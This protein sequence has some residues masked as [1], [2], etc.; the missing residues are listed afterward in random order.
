VIFEATT[1]CARFAA[2]AGSAALHVGFAVAVVAAGHSRST[3]SRGPDPLATIE[4]VVAAVEPKAAPTLERAHVERGD[5]RP[6]HTHRYPV[7]EN[8][9]RMPHDASLTHAPLTFSAPAAVERSAAP[10]VAAA[11]PY[12]DPRFV[13]IVKPGPSGQT[14]VSTR[15]GDVHATGADPIPES[16]VDAPA[17]QL[18]SETVAYPRAAR[19]SEVELDVP[20]EFVVDAQGRVTSVRVLKRAGYGLDEAAEQE[21]RARRFS[22]AFVHGR[23]TA[24]RM[25]R[26][27][28]FRLH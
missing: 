6:A 12:A 18:S 4:I 28:I 11:P 13:L 10:E 9:D 25:R 15:D 7:A 5:V 19:E 1:V 3:A 14:A 16:G 27:V 17:R 23:P 22:P 8:H 20:L 26:T 21:V 24:V 2:I